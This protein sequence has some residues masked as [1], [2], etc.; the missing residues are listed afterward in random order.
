MKVA[1][2][3]DNK[4]PSSFK[5]GAGTFY[6]IGMSAKHVTITKLGIGIVARE[7]LRLV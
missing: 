1:L 5:D 3:I 2:N 7:R 6:I 4:I